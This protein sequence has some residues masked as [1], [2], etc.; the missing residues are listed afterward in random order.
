M[1]KPTRYRTLLKQLLRDFEQLYNLQS[2]P[3]VETLLAFD[4]VREHFFLIRL[5]WAQERRVRH[6][7]LYVRLKDGKIWVEEDWTE[8]GIATELLKAGVPREDILL[9]FQPP[10]MRELSEFAV[11]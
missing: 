10:E 11:A 8:T 2:T 7:I 6:L 5:G 9:A 3:G 1:D 4:E